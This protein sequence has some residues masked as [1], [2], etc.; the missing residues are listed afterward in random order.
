M[1]VRLKVNRREA[2]AAMTSSVVAISMTSRAD[3]RSVSTIVKKH[4]TRLKQ[5]MDAQ[6]TDTR[7]RWCGTG[8]DQWGLY[9]C[10]SAGRILRDGAA[11]FF[12]SESQFHKSQQLFERMK[13][14]AD[15]LLRS[16]SKDGNI[17]LVTT[18]FN[19]PPDTGFVVHDVA[20]AA[21]LAQ[22][23]GHQKLLNLLKGFL[24][25]A[26]YG[27]AK[28]GIHTPNHRWVVGAA[29]A[30]IHELF[31][32]EQYL[33]RINQWLAEGID[34]DEEGQYIERSTTVYNAVTDN[35]LV[36]MAHKLKR[37]E[38]LDPVRKN[39]NA[40]TYLLHPTG[41]VVTEISRRQD[42]NTQ[43]TM[44]RYWFSLRYMAVKDQNG[45]YASMLRSVESDHIRLS[46][47]MEYPELQ[48]AL[49]TPMSLPDHYEKQY[50]LSN[51]TRIRRGKTSITI[52]HKQNSRWISIHH[53][54]TVVNAVRFA[55]AFFG[56]GQ[57]E[58]EFFE[59]REGE[60]H[61]RQELEAPYYQPL[62]DP[63]LLPVH[64]SNWSSLASKRQRTEIN[65][66]IYETKIRERP[67]GL[68]VIVSANGTDNVP[69][70]LEINLRKG[71]EL[72][73][74]V[75]APH[76]DEGFLLKSGYAEYR[77]GLDIIRFGPGQCEHAYI[78]IRGAQEKLHGPSVYVTGYTPFQY[79]LKFELL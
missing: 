76:V 45:L 62:T 53:G 47:L 52:I 51:V 59:K 7:S 20:T 24:E 69:L 58:P 44:A 64:R 32:D 31:P 63:N 65:R 18:N 25:R 57:F 67:G 60:F 50:P 74:V 8:P 12:H 37:S 73:G 10:H 22:I 54:R 17:D 5:A 14:A 35:A 79:T 70:A 16:Q 28:G 56:K 6:V 49:P 1:A 71:G 15:F 33:K 13:L 19:S 23:N 9:H 46:A 43:G 66:M 3:E 61:F 38:L 72:K 41:E 21:K 39:L 75:A 29:L 11:A 36:I 30:Q 55:T 42:L 48:K 4:D 40:M 34:I 27:M 68:D 77:T 2:I 26:G 78:Q